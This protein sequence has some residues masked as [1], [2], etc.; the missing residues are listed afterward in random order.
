MII[1]PSYPKCSTIDR[2]IHVKGASGNLVCCCGRFIID[3]FVQSVYVW[4]AFCT[5]LVCLYN[6]IIALCVTCAC[7]CNPRITPYSKVIMQ[8]RR[9]F[10]G[11]ICP[12]IYSINE[13]LIFTQIASH[14]AELS[15]DPHVGQKMSTP[16]TVEI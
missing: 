10:Q 8:H 7:R 15:N 11:Y 16:I 13:N 14:N 6:R 1:K 3:A 12:I 4:V 5:R 9:R 2:F